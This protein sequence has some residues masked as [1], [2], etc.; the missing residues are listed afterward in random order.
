MFAM[1]VFRCAKRSFSARKE[2]GRA[3]RNASVMKRLVL[4]TAAAG[5]ASAI[6][7]RPAVGADAMRYVGGSTPID[8][9]S[10]MFLAQSQGYFARAGV[11]IDVKPM[12]SGDAI[13][14]AIIGGEMAIGSMN[15]VSLAIAH[16]NGIALKI[17]APGPVYNSRF[18]GTKMM[19][20]NDST[21]ADASDLNGKT[22]AV[23]VLRGSAHLAAQAWIDKHG[24]DS[25]S[26]RWMESPYSLMEGALDAGR[27]DAA[28]ISEPAATKARLTCRLLADAHAAIA[29]QWL[30]AAYVSTESWITAHRDAMRRIRTALKQTAV[31]Y[32]GNHAATVPLI[33]TLAKQ[34]PDVVANSMRALFGENVEAGLIQP[35]IDVAARYGVLKAPFP[36][37][38]LIAPT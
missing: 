3:I 28:L 5:A 30:I 13:A 22:V 20:R 36:A 14:A 12:N 8:A 18:T 6:A 33:A 25:K 38:Q 29:P 15:V 9:D 24:G 37:D 35:V 31:W 32:N 2:A 16:Q 23:N 10:L 4:L 26:V 7:L 17:V 19:V 11:D 34:D 21:I 1:F 27:V